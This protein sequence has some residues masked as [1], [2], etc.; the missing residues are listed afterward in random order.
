MKILYP[1]FWNQHLKSERLKYH[2]IVF[3]SKPKIFRLA[4]WGTWS[5]GVDQMLHKQLRARPYIIQ[6]QPIWVAMQSP[7]LHPQVPVRFCVLPIVPA[8]SKEALS[9]Q[10]KETLFIIA[11]F[12]NF[13]N[14]RRW[15]QAENR[16]RVREDL[17]GKKEQYYMHT[18]FIKESKSRS[19]LESTFPL[20]RTMSGRWRYPLMDNL[21]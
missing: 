15:I 16:Y 10:A 7:T 5:R 4:S 19:V 8:I 18:S 20:L 6:M 9:R 12:Y 1:I 14:F 11:G 21:I 17:G 13:C 2:M 3:P